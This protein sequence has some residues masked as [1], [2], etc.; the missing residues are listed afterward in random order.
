MT[1]T[2]ISVFFLMRRRPPRS[3]RTD[4]L[5]P[6]T[7]LFRSPAPRVQAFRDD[8]QNLPAKDAAVVHVN[9]IG[10][11][12]VRDPH[13]RHVAVLLA[14]QASNATPFRSEEHTS[15][16]QSLMRIS[17]AVFCLQKKQ[18]QHQSDKTNYTQHINYKQD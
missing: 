6:Y 2:P 4:T 17:Y 9:N 18:Y 11:A 14:M 7:T 10:L 15:D 5:F 8:R 1:S 3:T 13:G 12:V 16:L